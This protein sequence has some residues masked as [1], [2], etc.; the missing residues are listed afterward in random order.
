MNFHKNHRSLVITS[1]VVFLLLSTGIAILP[2]LQMQENNAPLPDQP[3]LTELELRGLHVYIAEGCVGCHTQ[4]VRSIEMD[5]MWGNRPSIPSDYYYS[6]QRMD[7]WR[8]SPSLLGSERTGP[9]LTD[10]GR[11]QPSDD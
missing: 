11:R 10:I 6:K 2:A 5:N 7:V 3:E 1:F 9:D 8:Q 4:Q